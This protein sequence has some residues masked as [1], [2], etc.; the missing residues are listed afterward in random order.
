MLL[1]GGGSKFPTRRDQSE[2]VARI[3]VVTRH[4]HGISALVPQT[5]HFAGK[6]VVA[7]RDDGGF[8]GQVL[9]LNSF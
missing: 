1:I 6:T 9:C 3:R 7:S 8:L 4:Q 2:A 5:S